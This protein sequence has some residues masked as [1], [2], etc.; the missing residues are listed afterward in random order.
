[1]RIV[2]L[3]TKF[4]F[5]EIILLAV[6]MMNIMLL[7]GCDTE[8]TIDR[9]Q[10]EQHEIW[11]LASQGKFKGVEF[12]IGASKDEIIKKL[13]QPVNSGNTEIGFKMYY[14][15]FSYEFNYY[16][17]SLEDLQ[18]N[19]QVQQIYADS[20]TI[21]WVG[22][23]ADVKKL[24]GEPDHEFEDQ[25]YGPAWIMTYNVNEYYSLHFVSEKEGD[26]ILRLYIM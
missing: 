23:T 7:S 12:G 5:S 26:E 15:G 1:M 3:K 17:D 20:T 14:D 21:G 22:T 24:F 13:G 8:K 25:A 4:H 11:K 16:H 19:A 6:I 2:L 9:S 18:G 10:N